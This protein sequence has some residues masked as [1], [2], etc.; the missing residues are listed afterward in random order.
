MLNHR[1]GVFSFIQKMIL[2]APKLSSSSPRKVPF[3]P[4]S[5]LKIISMQHENNAV[6]N[7]L[8]FLQFFLHFW[9]FPYNFS[10]FTWMLHTEILNFLGSL[11]LRFSFTR[12]TQD[13]SVQHP[14]SLRKL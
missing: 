1:G 9:L 4:F 8:S 11:K 10:Q 13:F 14:G 2:T 6:S 12:K 7:H 3:E 5:V